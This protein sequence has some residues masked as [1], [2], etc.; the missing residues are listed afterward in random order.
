MDGLSQENLLIGAKNLTSPLTAIINQL[1]YQERTVS[2]R[3]EGGSRHTCTKKGDPKQ[4]ANYRPVSCLP[5]ASKLLEAVV[6]SQMNDYLEEIKLIGVNND[7]Q[8]ATE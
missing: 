4:L 6:C 1:V 8:N 7:D 5:V 2:Q 3:M